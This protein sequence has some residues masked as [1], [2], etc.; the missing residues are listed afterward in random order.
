MP[1]KIGTKKEME[2]TKAQRSTDR[3]LEYLS[4]EWPN[5]KMAIVHQARRGE[6]EVYGLCDASKTGKLLGTGKKCN[7][8]AVWRIQLLEP[9]RPNG[10]L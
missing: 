5:D 7:T 2:R 1:F 9:R 10:L 6:S 4:S 8:V 3:D